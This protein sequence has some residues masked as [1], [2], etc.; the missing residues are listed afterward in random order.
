MIVG[1]SL[2]ILG[3]QAVQAQRLLHGL[4][5]SQRVEV[6]FLAVNPRLPGILRHLQRVKY[7]RTVLT[8]IA[9]G[10][11]LLRRVPRADVVHAFL[12]LIIRICWHPCRRCSPPGCLGENPYS[13]IV[14]AK[15]QTTC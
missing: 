12:P 8:S 1:P 13:T 3:G 4:A 6:A 5:N 14:A 11:S 15:P 10:I 2:D 9:Y 7:L